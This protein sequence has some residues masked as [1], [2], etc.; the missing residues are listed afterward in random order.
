MFPYKVLTYISILVGFFNGLCMQL[1]WEV[2]VRS[3]RVWSNFIPEKK[4]GESE[5]IW[6][7]KTG[8]NTFHPTN[9]AAYILCKGSVLNVGIGRYCKPCSGWIVNVHCSQRSLYKFQYT[10]VASEWSTPPPNHRTWRL[11]KLDYLRSEKNTIQTTAP[12]LPKH[13][14]GGVL[15]PALYKWFWSATCVGPEHAVD[16]YQSLHWGFPHDVYLVK[17]WTRLSAICGSTRPLS[18]L[19]SPLF[20][21]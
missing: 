20:Y 14:I 2:L 15:I 7:N 13:R 8:K 16:I 9:K 3:W 4:A 5:S 17:N 6:L 10:L 11:Q 1:I 18:A 19:H 12:D 21:V